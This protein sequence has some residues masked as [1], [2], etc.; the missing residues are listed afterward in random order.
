MVGFWTPGPGPTDGDDE[1]VGDGTNETAVG[2]L[3]AD[4]LSGAG[5]VD[6]L[7]GDGYNVDLALSGADII[8]GGFGDDIIFGGAGSD[9]LTGGDGD[10]IIYQMGGESFSFSDT[11]DFRIADW[12][13][14][15]IDGG[16]GNDFVFLDYRDRA[17]AVTADFSNPALVTQILVGGVFAGS[18][19]GVESVE[20]R[21]GDGDDVITTGAGSDAI[22]VGDGNNT[23]VAGDGDDYIETSQ[24]SSSPSNVNSIDGG[25]GVDTMSFN[26]TQGP[27]NLVVNLTLGVATATGVSY[28][29][30]G[31]ENVA[32]TF[33]DD[34]ITGDN[35]ANI[36]FGANG[37]DILRGLDGADVLISD[38]SEDIGDQ[39]YGGL[40]DDLYVVRDSAFNIVELADEG[41][42]TVFVQAGFSSVPALLDF[43]SLAH[44][45][46]F[47]A[48]AKTDGF[49]LRANALDNVIRVGVSS[50]TGPVWSYGSTNLGAMTVYAGDGNDT[51]Y[52]DTNTV[53]NATTLYGEDG[54]DEL[55]GSIGAANTLIGGAGTDTVLGENLND[56]FII[57][58]GDLEANEFYSGRGGFD[59]L[60][61]TASS[62]LDFRTVTLFGISQLEFDG[63]T[64]LVTFAGESIGGSGVSSSLV[65][66]GAG[67]DRTIEI[68][69]TTSGNTDLSGWTV[70]NWS[71]GSAIVITGSA[72][73]D[74]LT[75]SDVDTEINGGDGNDTLDGGAGDDILQ[76]GDGDDEI[77]IGGGGAD[78]VQGGDGDDVIT[79][80]GQGAVGAV[81]ID[82]GAGLDVLIADKSLADVASIT[83]VEVFAF[84]FGAAIDPS[85]LAG[86]SVFWSWGG[87]LQLLG[88]D[89]VLDL[90]NVSVP[91]TLVLQGVT[92]TEANFIIRGTASNDTIIMPI[93]AGAEVTM[94]ADEGDDILTGG[95]EADRLEGGTGD[96]TIDGRGGD[97]RILW[98]E[99]DDLI[100]GGDGNDEI[101][102]SHQDTA[103]DGVVTIQGGDGTDRVYF[104]GGRLNAG[105]SFSGIE[106]FILGSSKHVTIAPGVLPST[107][108]LWASGGEIR[109]LNSGVTDLSNWTIPDNFVLVVPTQ[110]SLRFK[111][112]SGADTFMMPS[113]SGAILAST[114]GAG[115]D[116]VYAGAGADSLY[117]DAGDDIAYGR[118]GNDEIHGNANND[119]LFGEAGDDTLYGDEHDDVL[120]GGAGAD[121][122]HGGDGVDI[123]TASY[124]T[125][126]TGVTVNLQAPGSNTGDAVGDSHV[127]IEIVVGS[128][129]ADTMTGSSLAAIDLFGSDGA[130]T[131]NA[132]LIG[133]LLDGGSGD[134]VLTGGAGD[135]TVRG[136]DGADRLDGGNGNDDIYYDAADAVTF[137]TGGAGVDSLVFV[138]ISAP[139]SYNLVARG[140]EAARGQFADTGAESWD[141]Q[142]HHYDAQWR[143]G[144]SVVDNDDGTG[145]R[146]EYDLDSSQIWSA[147]WSH[148]LVS[149]G[150][151]INVLSFDDGHYEEAFYDPDNV[152]TWNASWNYYQANG[153]RTINTLTDDNGSY[154]ALYFD[155]DDTQAWSTNWNSHTAGGQLLA[156]DLTADDG[157]KIVVYYDPTNAVNWVSNW[158]SYDAGA[159]LTANAIVYD[160]GHQVVLYYDPTDAQN[161]ESN[162]NQYDSEDRLDLNVIENDDGTSIHVDYDASDQ[163]D[164]ASTWSLYDAGGNLIGFAG[165]NDDGST[166]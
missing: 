67:V 107:G 166:F 3:G 110:A 1:Y 134:D 146:I 30:A 113:S 7:S 81:S 13:S 153:G 51:V 158:N 43:S 62:A 124:A 154:I 16:V 50:Y 145:L 129:F 79:T 91:D 122:L 103:L 27:S 92:R 132:G 152:E 49:T 105:S 57:G 147:N 159:N 4:T 160:A 140:F 142:T 14:D 28:T 38:S 23:V 77:Q 143:L 37:D 130:D 165:V 69:R 108:T 9:T 126:T 106:L 32:G 83:G 151:D 54:D 80:T 18:V 26:R 96:D 5:G 97:D 133:V 21:T 137:V 63:A 59:T 139:T 29:L 144:A 48:T 99:G 78:D 135:D 52:G 98:I 89:P 35:G 131:L 162:W 116:V 71:A 34:D 39:M 41:T 156:N 125:A 11:V 119:T 31:I 42:D 136:G 84:R 111:G 90:T 60:S 44:I 163:F 6:W 73:P 33:R 40:G 94:F 10:D 68:V 53:G 148:Y 164:W 64:S 46:N 45:E 115:D 55:W 58:E 114:G 72:G 128:N 70:T 19:T 66:D 88:D 85:L 101:T 36:L 56:L 141:T 2:G 61:L 82:G 118:A 149:G 123:D 12:G 112:S 138:N 104:E 102:I 76:G 8:D 109:H 150:R 25:D 15:V 161:W 75:A 127:S 95:A 24:S 65:I 100:N 74:T 17:D 117:G 87:E 22:A 93:N 86:I 157:S 20:I 121:V 47:L 120:I 155:P